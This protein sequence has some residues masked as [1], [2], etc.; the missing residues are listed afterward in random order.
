MPFAIDWRLEVEEMKI[1]DTNNALARLAEIAKANDR[2]AKDFTKMFSIDAPVEALSP[3]DQYLA[4][5]E[6]KA[7]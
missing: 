3:T 2:H 5:L 6:K 4:D 7:S 1:E